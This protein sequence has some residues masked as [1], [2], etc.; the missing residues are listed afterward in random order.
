MRKKGKKKQAGMK[1]VQELTV[2][3][4]TKEMVEQNI[5]LEELNKLRITTKTVLPPEKA[6]ISIDGIPFFEI[7]DV[8][9]VKAKQKA[10]KTTMLKALVA[11]WMKGELFRLKSEL[12]EARVLWLDTEQKG[13][14]V[15]RI[16]DDVKHLSG[17]DDDYIDRHLKLY[18]V[19][20]L[21]HKTL[22]DDTK[23]LV[24]KYRPL[25]LIIDGLVDL[26]ESFNDEA[27]SHQLI[28]E[29]VMM[30]DN[31]ECAIIAVL[32]EN[33]SDADHNMRGHL[34]TM[35]AQK[36]GTVVQCAKDGNG[37]ITVSC[38]DS[39]HAAMPTWKIKYDES[40]HIIS[41]DGAQ[42]TAGQVEALRRVNLI[43]NIITDN[44]GSIS[45]KELT[46]KL[47]EDLQ[48]SRTRVANLIS[49]QLNK[50]ICENNNLIQIQPELDWPE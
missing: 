47:T 21:S 22:M 49:E 16:I 5:R 4:P 10:G 7:G 18:T 37:V 43:K 27:L 3:V 14:D 34:G 6:A 28:N 46:E 44:G 17:Q 45:R 33:K 2:V 23:L 25:V 1:P 36:A 29:L 38:S 26:I 48:L 15:K 24:S 35:L 50:S 40:G 41:A 11:A 12:E 32:H 20:T 19:R 8:G 13:H 9:A 30:S 42:T 31:Y 39:R